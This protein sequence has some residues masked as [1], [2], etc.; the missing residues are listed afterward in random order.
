MRLREQ[1][2]LAGPAVAPGGMA[3]I[4]VHLDTGDA[5]VYAERVGATTQIWTGPACGNCRRDGA[6]LRR[7]N[8]HRN[9]LIVAEQLRLSE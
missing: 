5:W 9:L 3:S 6:E 1:I 7:C 8:L 4:Q 2:V